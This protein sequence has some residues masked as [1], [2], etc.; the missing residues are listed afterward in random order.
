[1]MVEVGVDGPVHTRSSVVQ[2]RVDGI[3]ELIQ[4]ANMAWHLSMQE[5]AVVVELPGNH[6]IFTLLTLTHDAYLT[7]K[8]FHDVVD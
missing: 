1:M 2:M 7:G 5:E 3:R 4:I 6:Y 8:V